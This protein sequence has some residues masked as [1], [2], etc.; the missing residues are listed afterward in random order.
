[1]EEKM[2]KI[3]DELDPQETEQLLEGIDT[4]KQENEK[5]SLNEERIRNMVFEKIDTRKDK[6]KKIINFNRAAFASVAAAVVI[7][8]CTAVLYNRSLINNSDSAQLTG[9]EPVTNSVDMAQSEDYHSEYEIEVIED[10][11]NE[12]EM[13]EVG[14]M[15][16]SSSEDSDVDDNKTEANDNKS[17]NK[18][19]KPVN[20]KSDEVMVGEN[21]KD[22]NEYFSEKEVENILE[23]SDTI[24]DMESFFSRYNNLQEMIDNSDYIVRGE[25]VQSKFSPGEEN[26]TYKLVT[27]FKVNEL[28]VDNEGNDISEYI[29]IDESIIYNADTET[30]TRIAG[31]NHMEK[32]REYVLFLKIGE[33]GH[34]KIAGTVYG[35][36]SVDELEKYSDVD[37]SCMEDEDVIIYKKIINEARENYMQI[38]KS[39]DDE[40]DSDVEN[41]SQ[42]EKI[43]E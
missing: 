17:D 4:G 36:V 9:K 29:K 16:D 15:N 40:S 1:M 25:K 34:Y 32:D 20:N 3:L 24:I 23:N 21:I 7:F 13:V 19:R 18:N 33:D 12:S 30:L 31:Y 26:N 35:K 10:K 42:N 37:T 11:E 6:P 22:K 43:E 2:K 14:S 38:K 27:K 39:R 28:I 5:T 8:V 41:D